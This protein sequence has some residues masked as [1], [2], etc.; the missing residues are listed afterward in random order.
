[1]MTWTRTLTSLA[2]ASLLLAGCEKEKTS[3]EQKAG[4]A[5]AQEG[6]AVDPELAEA[7]KSASSKNRAARGANA[8]EDE[9]GPPANGIF[10]PGAADAELAKGAAP[11]IT[12]GSEGSEPRIRLT[13]GLPAA[14]WKRSGS[15]ELSI[16]AGRNQL[17][18]ITTELAFE[19]LKPK[20]GE[21][22]GADGETQVAVK[23]V[24]AGM[25]PGQAGAGAAELEQVLRQMKGSGVGFR[26]LPNGASNDFNVALAKDAANDLDA[27]L[28]PLSEVLA[29]VTMPYPDKEVGTGAFWM[30]TSRDNVMG[31]DV[32]TYRMVRVE[33]IRDSVASLTVSIK[34]YAASPELALPGVPADAKL[35]QFQSAAEGQLE[36]GADAS[37]LPT[38]GNL[39]QNL[40]AMLTP[41]PGTDPS[42]RLSAQTSTDATL[43]FPAPA[44]KR[45][46]PAAP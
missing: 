27:F 29:A 28:R 40:V 35:E 45:P 9:K 3:S 20:A 36:V 31:V 12:L 44:A 34:R 32:V 42:Q 23:V 11:K 1:M 39:K 16:R 41:P 7:M 26:V 15:V 33:E 2:V 37:L 21:A 17:P 38:S 24:K 13:A 14:G 22:P 43:S 19:A 30:V 6:P 18:A 46:K 5:A 25:A 4:D 8:L 10:A